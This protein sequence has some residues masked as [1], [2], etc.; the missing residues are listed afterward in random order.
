MP[1]NQTPNIRTIVEE[2]FYGRLKSRK[3]TARQDELFRTL[4]PSISIQ[5]FEDIICA[6]KNIYLEIGFGCGE[7]IAQLA[8]N[9]PDALYIGSEPFVNGVASLL[10]KIDDL[11]LKNIRIYQNDARKI[12][13]E[14]PEGTIS[15]AFLLFPDPWPKRKHIRRR[16]LQEQ[17][18][19]SIHKILKPSGTWR[20][21][22]DH[23][24]YRTW[25]KKLLS[26]P[27]VP[28]LFDIKFFNRESRPDP[29]EWPITR[30]EQKA[31]DEILFSTLTK[32]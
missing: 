23:K 5:K 24:E 32:I 14:I 18:I 17:T 8:S 3:L 1:D 15:G 30:Y 31:T 19:R 27:W 16:F 12:I 20:I 9:N 21:A 7:H 25:I 2:K 4:Y 13:S 28:D 22:S 6:P 26:L 29:S 10:T 11:N